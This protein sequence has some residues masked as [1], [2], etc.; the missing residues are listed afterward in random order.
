MSNYKSKYFFEREEIV[1]LICAASGKNY[2]D[3]R[4]EFEKWTEQK[5]KAQL[6]YLKFGSVELS[7]SMAIARLVARETSLSGKN[8]M[9]QAQAD[10][11]VETILEFVN[12]YTNIL[13]I[14]DDDEKVCEG[15]SEFQ[16]IDIDF[17]RL[18]LLEALLK[19]K[20]QKVQ[21]MWKN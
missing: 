11:I 9:E 10:A 8:N 2:S 20:E 18:K 3:D 12:H 5:N 16:Y 6:P 19:N 13:N 15:I 7:Q 1:R 17:L 21:K 14:H 4:I